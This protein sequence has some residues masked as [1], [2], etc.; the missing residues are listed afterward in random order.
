MLDDLD[1]DL[2]SELQKDSRQANI[3]LAKKLGI[4]EATVRR[5][6]QKITS[7]NAIQFKIVVNPRV[8][9]HDLVV[10]LFLNTKVGHCRRIAKELAL[11]T[12]IYDV[13]IITGLYDIVAYGYFD[14]T[15]GLRDFIANEIG[16]IEGIE[17]LEICILLEWAKRAYEAVRLPYRGTATPL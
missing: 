2:I 14:S 11:R 12:N 7:T 16:A 9:G 4:A 15:D 1:L 13:A 6:L 3:Q 8:F 5:R 10:V 17:R